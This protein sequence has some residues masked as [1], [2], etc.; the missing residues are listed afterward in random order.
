MISAPS[1]ASSTRS[2]ATHVRATGGRPSTPQE[3]SFVGSTPANAATGKRTSFHPVGRCPRPAERTASFPSVS[4]TTTR[5]SMNSS[6]VSGRSKRR[7]MTSTEAVKV[8]RSERG[9]AAR[10]NGAGS[11]RRSAMWPRLRTTN[12]SVSES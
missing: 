7:P 2:A 8:V 4:A 11:V 3:L 12:G 6:S 9:T 10:S 1:A 5:R